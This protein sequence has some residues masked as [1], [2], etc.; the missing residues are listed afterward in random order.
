MLQGFTRMAARH[1]DHTYTHPVTPRP[2]PLRAAV[3]RWSQVAGCDGANARSPC[4]RA[5]FRAN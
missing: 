3:D 1:L 4:G 2:T 5:V